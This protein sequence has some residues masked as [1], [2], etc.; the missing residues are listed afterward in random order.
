MSKKIFI[1][2]GGTGGHIIPARCLA[3][4][5]AAQKRE[6]VFLGD[7]KIASYIKPEDAFKS[8][9]ICSSQLQKSVIFV[10]AKNK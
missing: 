8:E 6:V 3:K 10:I 9:F 5:L 1:V 2:S 4:H 7:R